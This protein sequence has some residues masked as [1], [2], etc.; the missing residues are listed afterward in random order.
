MRR[1]VVS[2]VLQFQSSYGSGED[3]LARLRPVR[4]VCCDGDW[5][6]PSVVMIMFCCWWRWWVYLVSKDWCRALHWWRQQLIPLSCC[7]RAC[8]R[9]WPLLPQDYPSDNRY[10]LCLFYQ[11]TCKNVFTNSDALMA[12][13]YVVA[14]GMTPCC[15][16]RWVRKLRRCMPPPIHPW[17]W[18]QCVPQRDW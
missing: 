7:T 18:V 17:K 2:V 9:Q 3:V 15:C 4:V 10:D 14:W 6:D 5:Y 13:I 11:M 1:L 16:S 8:Q 12:M